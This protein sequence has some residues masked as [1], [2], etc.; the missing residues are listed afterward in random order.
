[1][2]EKS[3]TYFED[4]DLPQKL[5]MYKDFNWEICKQKIPEEVVK[6]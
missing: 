6:L 1:M 4:V 2:V 3:L 5:I